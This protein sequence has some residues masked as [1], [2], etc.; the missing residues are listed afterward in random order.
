MPCCIRN[1]M[2]F[3]HT[4]LHTYIHTC[5]RHDLY[6]SGIRRSGDN[7]VGAQ[8]Q[9]CARSLCVCVCMYVCIY[10]CL[11]VCTAYECMCSCTFFVP[12]YLI[13][14]SCPNTY[15]CMYVCIYVVY[16]NIIRINPFMHETIQKART[17][18]KD[19]T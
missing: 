12:D 14:S 15:V 8:P 19:R 9:P 4:L 2:T 18:H 17:L 11:Y 13:S 6:Q 10:A 16:V 1:K 7:S 3:V 5:V